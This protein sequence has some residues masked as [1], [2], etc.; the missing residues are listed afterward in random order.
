MC[1]IVYWLRGK[2]IDVK[3]FHDETSILTVTAHQVNNININF[4]RTLLCKK[5]LLFYQVMPIANLYC[6]PCGIPRGFINFYQVI[7]LR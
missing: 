5:I 4:V 2:I 1:F 7:L 6:F 3:K